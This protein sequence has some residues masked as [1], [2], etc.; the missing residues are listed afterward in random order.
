[1][2]PKIRQVVG[3]S[4]YRRTLRNRIV[5]KPM[6]RP[7]APLT[8]PRYRIALSYFRQVVPFRDAFHDRCARKHTDPFSFPSQNGAHSVI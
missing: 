2:H 6:H 7:D 5:F 1:M 3:T 4:L 8:Q